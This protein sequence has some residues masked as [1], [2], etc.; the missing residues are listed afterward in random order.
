MNNTRIVVD[1]FSCAVED[2]ANYGPLK[3]EEIRGLS[4]L[5]LMENA[6]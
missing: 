6:L 3:P 2:L 4:S 1:V 5:D